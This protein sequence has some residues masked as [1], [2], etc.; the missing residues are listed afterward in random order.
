MTER[1]DQ[2]TNNLRDRL[3]TA[4]ARLEKV[5]VSIGTADTESRAYIEGKIAEAKAVAEEQ[6]ASLKDG[7][8]KMKTNL[9]KNK[10]V[11]DEKV[12]KWKQ[13]RH[14]KKLNRRATWAEDDAVLA[15]W[16]ASDRIDIANLRT[17]EAIVA[18]MDADEAAAAAGDA[19]EAASAAG[20]D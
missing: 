15:I 20:A 3:N 8:A 12:S 4:E 14:V 17:L 5:K 1:V 10:A 2:F 7:K 13:E 9:E 16:V 6:K 19:D 18:R 11:T